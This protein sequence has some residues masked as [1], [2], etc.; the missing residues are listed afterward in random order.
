VGRWNR[1]A[2]RAFRQHQRGWARSRRGLGLDRLGAWRAA[3][4]RL[5]RLGGGTRFGSARFCSAPG[6]RRAA[7]R[8]RGR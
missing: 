4:G 5:G 2:G 1:R 7:R 3:A 8:L 6:W